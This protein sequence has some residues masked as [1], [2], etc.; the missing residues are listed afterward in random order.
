MQI[1]DWKFILIAPDGKLFGVRKLDEIEEVLHD[2]EKRYGKK[3]DFKMTAV[4]NLA[5]FP[6]AEICDPYEF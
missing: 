5:E 2:L 1:A 4:K 6:T 3:T